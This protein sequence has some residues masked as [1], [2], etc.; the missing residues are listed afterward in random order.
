MVAKG[1]LR[2][3]TLL[4]M[5]F[6]LTVIPTAFATIFSAHKNTNNGGCILRYY[7]NNISGALQ[8]A[9]QSV[10]PNP[11]KDVSVSVEW[12]FEGALGGKTFDLHHLSNFSD[13]IQN[14]SG[15]PPNCNS[16]SLSKACL[17][18][19]A[20]LNKQSHPLAYT[21]SDHNSTGTNWHS[22]DF[23]VTVYLFRVIFGLPHIK[24]TS[25][26][27]DPNEG[28]GAAFAPLYSGLALAWGDVPVPLFLAFWSEARAKLFYWAV[29]AVTLLS[30]IVFT[31]S[32]GIIT[33]LISQHHGTNDPF[34]GQVPVATFEVSTSAS[35]RALTWLSVIFSYI[36]TGA[37]VA[38]MM[39]R[40]RVG[41]SVKYAGVEGQET[42]EE[43]KD[44]FNEPLEVCRI[45]LWDISDGKSNPPTMTTPKILFL[46]ADYGHDP[47]ET[48]LPYSAFKS[49]GFQIT[50]ATETGTSPKCDSK[51]LT[52]L[53]QKLL[54][55]PRAAI[56]AYNSML[57]D[58]PIQ[59]PLSWSSDGFS[60]DEYNLVFLPG[61]HDKGVRQV[62]DSAVVKRA[63]G[64]YF[65]KC[66]PG[67]SKG[68]AAICH[69]V[70]ILSECL[71][72]EGRSVMR[73]CKTTTLPGPF[74]TG[75]YWGT[76]AFLGD[77][78]KTYGPKSENCE[79]MVKKRL[80]DP[81]K[82]FKGSVQA[83]PFVVEDDKYNYV[84]GRYPADA[85]LLAAKAIAMVK[86]GMKS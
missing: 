1:T 54:G 30:A 15:Y 20:I 17:M 78:Y 42:E 25:A 75:I 50:F 53:T 26:V 47:T 13:S 52:G 10:I 39:A 18:P 23:G 49:A 70:L 79:D 4:S 68:V 14:P 44:V 45:W 57:E 40:L 86:A 37:A 58:A 69:G 64:G 12:S 19:N 60:L 16:C 35:S 2:G 32:A 38:M 46:M 5:L 7:G 22:A 27:T 74:E 51:M 76:R 66:T 65:E 80:D 29:T 36:A 11:Y 85:D 31:V 67:G 21:S 84:S 73:G 24:D 72:G 77:Y 55:A 48:A 41:M 3:F 34:N 62:I 61:G 63:L 8:D 9:F 71:D 28:T 81:K 82:Q 6:V 43:P 33:K 56:D 83:G 59:A